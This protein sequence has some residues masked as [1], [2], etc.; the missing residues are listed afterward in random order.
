MP[1]INISEG[2]KSIGKKLPPILLPDYAAREEAVFTGMLLHSS[3]LLWV[4][5]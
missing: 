4:T 3:P 2:Q 5:W 1:V